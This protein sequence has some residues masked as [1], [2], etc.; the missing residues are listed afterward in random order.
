M[1]ARAKEYGLPIPILYSLPFT[2]L[3]PLLLLSSYALTEMA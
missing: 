3:L 2:P 1:I